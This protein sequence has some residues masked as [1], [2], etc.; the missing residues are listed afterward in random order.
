VILT[1][2]ISRI[3]VTWQ[4]KNVK[5]LDDDTEMSKHVGVYIIRK[6]TVVMYICAFVGC[7]KKQ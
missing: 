6:D 3:Y 5:L 1:A 4:G 7:N 2:S